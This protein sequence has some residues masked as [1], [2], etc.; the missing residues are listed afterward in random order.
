MT[1][2]SGAL[3]GQVEKGGT[4]GGPASNVKDS[5]DIP[6]RRESNVCGAGDHHT[7]ACTR[8]R[9]QPDLSAY[10]ICTSSLLDQPHLQ[11]EDRTIETMAILGTLVVEL[12]GA[13][14]DLCVHEENLEPEA[15]VVNTGSECARSK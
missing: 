6:T 9:S 13:K 8:I 14:E 12:V 4:S 7:R 3:G 5:R 1:R 10:L 15:T 2:T 11:W